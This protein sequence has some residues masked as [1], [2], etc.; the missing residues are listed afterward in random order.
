MARWWYEMLDPERHRDFMSTT[1]VGGLPP[2]PVDRLVGRQV[3]VVRAA[4]FTFQFMDLGHLREALAHFRKRVHPSSREAGI[5]LEHYWQLWYE[6]LPQWLFAEP[7]RVRVVSGLSRALA[8]FE[9]AEAKAG[10]TRR[11][12]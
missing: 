3:Y 2:D 4:G 8:A 11:R 1:H 9:A 6:R 10:R 7:R 5:E 12:I